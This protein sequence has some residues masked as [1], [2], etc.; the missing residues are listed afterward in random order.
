MT[1]HVVNP[2]GRPLA[3]VLR[4]RL[5]DCRRHTHVVGYGAIVDDVTNTC[6]ELLSTD[7]THA[8]QVDAVATVL[9]A[10]CVVHLI[11][12]DWQTQLRHSVIQRLCTA[13]TSAVYL[14]Q[15]TEVP[16]ES[17]LFL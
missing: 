14:F 3:R 4:T 8:A 15:T 7:V 11:S 17:D 12:K 2:P 10:N 16:T 6:D 13:T 5:E 1:H 9:H